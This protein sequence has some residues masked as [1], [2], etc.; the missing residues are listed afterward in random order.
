MAD[1]VTQ[2][3]NQKSAL[4]DETVNEFLMDD[5]ELQDLD[6]T[7][8]QHSITIQESEKKDNFSQEQIDYSNKQSRVDQD[9]L[10]Q[11]SELRTMD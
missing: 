8:E 1:E 10:L 7:E 2:G 4:L 6:A 9:S 3:G 11:P 5:D